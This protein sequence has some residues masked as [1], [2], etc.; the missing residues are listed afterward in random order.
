[1]TTCTRCNGLGWRAPDGPEGCARC[2]GTGQV[3]PHQFDY[4]DSVCMHCG[5]DK[6]DPVHRKEES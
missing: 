5:R 2:N 6:H 1:M 4:D 3:Q